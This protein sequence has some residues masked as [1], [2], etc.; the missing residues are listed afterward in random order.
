MS[1]DSLMYFHSRQNV[2]SRVDKLTISVL[3][4]AV[5]GASLHRQGEAGQQGLKQ[6]V[7]VL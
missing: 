5:R 1:S 7:R 4:R 6:Q 3:C 2:F